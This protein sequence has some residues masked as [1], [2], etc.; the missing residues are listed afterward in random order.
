MKLSKMKISLFLLPF[1]LCLLS[2]DGLSQVRGK[3]RGTVVDSQGN[4]VDKAAVTIV[5]TR[6]ASQKYETK[7]GK[8]GRFTQVGIYPGYYQ[9][10]IKKDGFLPKTFEVHVEIDGEANLEVIKLETADEQAMKSLSGADRAFIK[11]NEYYN[12]QD[13]EK[14]V[15]GFQEAIGLSPNNWAYHFNLGLAYK[16]L[17][18]LVEARAAFAKAVELNPDSFSANKEMGELLARE[19]EFEAA[20]GYY[21]KAVSLSP[22]DPDAHYNLGVC[23]VNIGQSEEAQGHFQMAVSLKPDYA[24]AY[25]QLGSIYISHNKKEEAITSLEKFIELAPQHEKAAL[26]RQLLE[27][28]KK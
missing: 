13:Y 3:V 6:L 7:T 25:F 20:S 16:K 18:K 27:Y 4:P 5:S 12:K 28:L 11:A 19:S 2:L 21:R 17:N 8:D 15:A 23:L 14:A 26:A 22:N 10:T 9:V 24:E 1:L